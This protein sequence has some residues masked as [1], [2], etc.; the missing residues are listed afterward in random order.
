MKR[1]L[2]LLVVFAFVVAVCPVV[3]ASP[4]DQF[5]KGADHIINSPY[6]IQDAWKTEPNKSKI[7]VLGYA[8]A[9][10]KGT[11]LMFVDVLRGSVEI[12]TSPVSA[13]CELK[14]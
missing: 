2:S 1:T 10:V 6:Q 9:I 4:A 13:L 11:A 5:K 7:L 14:K 12:L 8:G 3:F